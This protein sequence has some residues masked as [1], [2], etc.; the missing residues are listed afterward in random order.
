MYNKAVIFN[1]PGHACYK[2]QFMVYVVA[3]DRVGGVVF[4]LL[5]CNLCVNISLHVTL[6][7]LYK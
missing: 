3:V 6:F 4:L 1:Y 5:C 7:L 2:N